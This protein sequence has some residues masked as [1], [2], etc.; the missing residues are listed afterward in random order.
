[1]EGVECLDLI[2]TTI[3][4][5]LEDNACHGGGG[6][7]REVKG[8]PF[9]EKVGDGVGLVL[10]GDG[11]VEQEPHVAL[12]VVVLLHS[13]YRLSLRILVAMPWCCGCGGDDVVM[14]MWI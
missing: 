8:G 2:R 12:G 14:M 11:A 1:M 9:F 4:A 6:L 13:F 7:N 3:A 10:E 5:V